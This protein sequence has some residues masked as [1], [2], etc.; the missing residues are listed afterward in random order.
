MQLK[1]YNLF[2]LNLKKCSVCAYCFNKKLSRQLVCNYTCMLIVIFILEIKITFQCILKHN[3]F[4]SKNSLKKLFLKT[5]ILFI[6]LL[7]KRNLVK[8]YSTLIQKFSE[9]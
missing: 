1:I 2:N 8:K 7:K 9:I 6:F 5:T 3:I 4:L